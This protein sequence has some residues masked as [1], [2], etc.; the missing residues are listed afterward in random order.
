MEEAVVE[1]GE[2]KGVGLLQQACSRMTQMGPEG[3]GQN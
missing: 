2:G 1:V 3:K